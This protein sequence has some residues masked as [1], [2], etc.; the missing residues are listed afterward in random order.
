M[1]EKKSDLCCC[2][3]KPVLGQKVRTIVVLTLWWQYA[4]DKGRKT[5]KSK[6]ENQNNLFLESGTKKTPTDLSSTS[7]SNSCFPTQN[8]TKFVDLAFKSVSSCN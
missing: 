6:T 4:P 3:V 5:T 2:S 7:H 1:M 8:F